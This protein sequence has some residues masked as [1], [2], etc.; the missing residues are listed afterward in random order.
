ME[1]L[2]DQALVKAYIES[3]G[4]NLNSDF[5]HVFKKEIDKRGLCLD[6][7]DLTSIE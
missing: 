4:L 6:S 2:S 3:R 1:N 7:F 5:I